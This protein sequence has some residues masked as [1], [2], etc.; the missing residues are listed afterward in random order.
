LHPCTI[1]R[2]G[3]PDEFEN[4]AQNEVQTHFDKLT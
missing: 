1:P 2:A 4:M 3:W